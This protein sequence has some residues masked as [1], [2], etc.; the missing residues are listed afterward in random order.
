MLPDASRNDTVKKRRVR[1]PGLLRYAAIL[2]VTRN[3]LYLVLSGQRE[4]RRLMRDY[5]TIT[6]KERAA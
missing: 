4:S 2:G 1:F 3:H 6:R 5:K